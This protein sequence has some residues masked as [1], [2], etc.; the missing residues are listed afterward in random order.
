MVDFIVW[1]IDGVC[2]LLWYGF[3]YVLLPILALRFLWPYVS[4]VVKLLA[5]AVPAVIV[6]AAFCLCDVGVGLLSLGGAIVWYV[7]VWAVARF[8]DGTFGVMV[9]EDEIWM[10]E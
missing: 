6:I 2:M 7:V 1:L 9:S 3:L 5:I 4:G 10:Q 8:L